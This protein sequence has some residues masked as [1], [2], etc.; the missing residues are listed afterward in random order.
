MVSGPVWTIVVAA[1]S[2]TRFGT[3]KLACVL[4]GRS[5][6]D[7]SV[8]NARAHADGVVLVRSEHTPACSELVDVCVEGGATRSASVRRG[9]AAV[10]PD[11]AIVV[12]HDAARPLA[13]PELFA[14]VIAAVRR[15]A[16]G[17]ITA[18]AVVDT[19]KRVDGTTVVETLDR[20]TLVSVQ[21]PQAF[22]ADVLRRAHAEH[23]EATDDAALI[24]RLGG[25]VV[26]AGGD[27]RNGKITTMADVAV[28]DA[29]AAE[30][31]AART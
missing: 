14:A 31:D 18:V 19:V 11:A 22:R 16:D 1:G 20:A 2:A 26:V 27:A 7:R 30:I 17:A 23:G 24:E 29:F 10:P 8:A 21:T 4:A 3:S 5:V 15:G 12:V 6:L 13:G 25:V 28:L 9:L